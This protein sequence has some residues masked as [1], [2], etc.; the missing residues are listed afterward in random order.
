MN[1]RKQRDRG[2]VSVYEEASYN[3]EPVAEEEI[4]THTASTKLG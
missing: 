4:Y 1:R 2:R 3:A